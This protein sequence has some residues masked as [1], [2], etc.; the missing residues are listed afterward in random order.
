MTDDTNKTSEKSHTDTFPTVNDNSP[1]VPTKTHG[2]PVTYKN[3]DGKTI[4]ALKRV[5]I[6]E[7]LEL[8]QLKTS[9]NNICRIMSEK[10]NKSIRSVNRWI[11]QAKE[12]R[13]RYFNEQD[14]NLLENELIDLQNMEQEAY[15]EDYTTVLDKNGNQVDIPTMTKKGKT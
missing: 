13:A 8:L 5:V 14:K 10:Y 15:T 7:I 4:T 9:S 2:Y 12:E 11:A 1:T 3:K 6:S